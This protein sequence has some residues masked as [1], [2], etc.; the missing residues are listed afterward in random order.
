MIQIE[1]TA[2]LSGHQNPIFTL[3]NSQKAGIVFTGGNDKGVVEWNVKT[4]GF[5]KV[6]FPVKSSVY[7]LHCPVSAPL[8]LAGE[9]SG[10]V[11]VFNFDEQKIVG[12]LEYH[13]L[14]VFDIKSVPSKNELI[15]SS[16]DGTVSIWDIV[17]LK[18]IFSFKVSSETVR[19]ISIS[20]DERT[21]AFG[22][23]DNTISI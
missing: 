17:S 6:I 10:Q 11:D 19:V 5:I 13:T 15:I 22:C 23:K 1:N 12:V 3:E 7:S 20:P 4:P 9:R 8:L 21:V 2:T 16:E 14:P 18:L